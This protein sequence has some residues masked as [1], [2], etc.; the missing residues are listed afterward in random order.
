MTQDEKTTKS[1]CSGTAIRKVVT[2]AF[3]AVLSVSTLTAPQQTEASIGQKFLQARAQAP[4]PLAAH[5]LCE[6]Y[7]W[8]CQKSGAATAL[9]QQDIDLV[10]SINLKVNRKIREVSDARQY[11]KADYWTL[12]LSSRGDCEDF[13]LLKKQMLVAEGIAPERLLIATVLDQNR[14]GHAVLILRADSGDY[15]LDNLTNRIKPWQST[16]YM[17]LRMQNPDAPR[18]WVGLLVRG[19]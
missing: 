1:L 18:K 12:P 3:A 4:A 13:A 8:A 11:R 16:R 14:Q 6:K 10:R 9:T 5:D 7:A 17:Y 15:V 19:S 2:A